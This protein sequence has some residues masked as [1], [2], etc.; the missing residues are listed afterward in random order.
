MVFLTGCFAAWTVN[1]TG[2]AK[3]FCPNAS[4]AV[5]FAKLP[6]SPAPLRVAG[7]A[8]S[9]LKLRSSRGDRLALR[10]HYIAA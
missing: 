8:D 9:G 2:L 6:V 5:P 3:R 1:Q 7:I 4:T 10:L